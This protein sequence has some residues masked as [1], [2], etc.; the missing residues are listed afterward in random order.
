MTL[1][2]FHTEKSLGI[3]QPVVPAEPGP[4]LREAVRV[5]LAAYSPKS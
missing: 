3:D 4:V 2:P 5:F 1:G